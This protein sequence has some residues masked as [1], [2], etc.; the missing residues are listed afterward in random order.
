[1]KSRFCGNL[2]GISLESFLQMAEMENLSCTLTVKTGDQAG[3]LYLNEGKLISAKTDGLQNLDA[4]YRIIS[5]EKVV[6]EIEDACEKTEDNINQPLMSILM[7][8]SRLKDEAGT[9]PK[10]KNRSTRP[11]V[12]E[13]SELEA[14]PAEDEEI[15]KVAPVKDSAKT[16]LP[17][18]RRKWGIIIVCCAVLLAMGAGTGAFL[19]SLGSKKNAY[20]TLMARVSEAETPGQKIA[21][22]NTFIASDP[23]STYADKAGKQIDALKTSIII[24]AREYENLE[25]LAGQ[26]IKNN[27][28][29]DAIAA[30]DQYQETNPAN[31]YSQ[32]IAEKKRELADQ[33]ESRDFERMRYQTKDLGPERLEIYTAFLEKYP[34]TR[35]REKISELTLEMEE[36]YYRYFSHQIAEMKASGQWQQ[37]LTLTRGFLGTYPLSPYT[38]TLKQFQQVCEKNIRAHAT[39]EKLVLKANQY[40]NDWESALSVF[41]NFLKDNPRTLEKAKIN[42]EIERLK[43]LLDTDRRN[44]ARDN[45]MVRLAA[46]SRFDVSADK[47]TVKD[48]KTGLIWCL[49]D[50][51]TQL[52]RC[53]S[54]NEAQSYVEALKTGGYENWRLPSPEE[55]L[56]LYSP[57]E[58]FPHDTS[59]QWYWTS[60][61]YRSYQ[62]QWNLDVEV[63]VPTSEGADQVGKES[64]QCGA[65]RAVY[66]KK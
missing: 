13:L 24:I 8:A 62:E 12:A 21:L 27:A 29:E 30:Y 66:S 45:I 26:L 43:G 16:P 9:K 42:A 44:A 35:Y 61:Y 51:Q 10:Q 59:S 32:K 20:Q 47:E 11:G 14:L 15:P 17:P 41:S 25:R 3:Y 40:G 60:K 1:M 5:W 54:Y 50:S 38:D 37:A 48:K 18:S 6:I 19:I 52:N 4:A 2:Q 63:I 53:L 49:L 33:M 22:L 46:N 64:R 65:V 28:F 7:E 31:E 34:E 36:E 23:G 55:V 58:A 56:K 39:F 57:K